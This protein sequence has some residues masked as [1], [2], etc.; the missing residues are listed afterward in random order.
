MPP[1]AVHH[2]IDSL[3]GYKKEQGKP[4][5]GRQEIKNGL[6]T[7]GQAL[8]KYIDVNVA[9]YCLIVAPPEEDHDCQCQFRHLKGT[10]QWAMKQVSA[11]HIDPGDKHERENNACPY[12]T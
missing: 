3:P 1:D 5:Q 6:G 10:D 7:V 8:I 4:Q 9:F 11:Y 12:A 2:E